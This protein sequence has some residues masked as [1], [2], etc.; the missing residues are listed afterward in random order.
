MSFA[1]RRRRREIGVRMAVGASSADAVA[2]V[3]R[4]AGGLVAAGLALG[5]LAAL[6]VGRLLAGMLF[7]VAPHDLGSLAAVAAILGAAGLAAAWLPARS[8]ARVDPATVLRSE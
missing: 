2:L 6:A 7:G 4:E 1:V 5:L 8:A 3:L